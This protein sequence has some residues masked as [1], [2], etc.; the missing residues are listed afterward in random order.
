MMKTVQ[1]SHG[2]GGEEMGMLVEKLF[3]RYFSN[4]ILLKAEDA[5]VLPMAG[6]VAFTTDSFT[7][8]PLFFPGGNIGKLAVAGTVNDLAMVGAEPQ[9][10]SSSF[11]IEE[12]FSFEELTDI[13]KTMATELE[14][15][16]AQIVCG[17]TKVVPRGTLE[18]L[19]INTSGIGTIQYPG[20]SAS[21]LQDGD[22]IIVS[23][24]IGSHGSCILMARDELR[25]ESELVSDCDTLWPRVRQLIDA[26]ITL[27]ALRDATRGGLAAVL[28]EWCSASQVQINVAEEQIPVLDE[29]RGLCEIYGFEPYELANEGTMVIAVPQEHIDKTLKVLRTFDND[30]CCIGQVCASERHKVIVQSPW[31]SSRYMEMPRGELLPR[32]C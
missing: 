10:L 31:G 8:S 29:V 18:G 16:G 32:I 9:Y 21:N 30:A 17:D 26:G 15:S 7:V 11:V 19:I 5:A 13:V 3:Y 28:N 1:L 24:N 12:G 4:D 27:H 20:L 25:M 23:R 2:S 22:A 6:P 14:K